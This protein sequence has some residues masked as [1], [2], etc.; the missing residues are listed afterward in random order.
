M[1]YFSAH[2]SSKKATLSGGDRR[3]VADDRPLSDRAYHEQCVSR[4][5][6]FFGPDSQEAK[7]VRQF[8]ISMPTKDVENIFKVRFKQQL[9]LVF[10]K[11]F[12]NTNALVLRIRFC[13]NFLDF[14][15]PSYRLKA[16]SKRF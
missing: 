10:H 3:Q 12:L 8:T 6:E 15:S 1:A 13:S 4:L 16:K 14:P 11:H 2:S 9:K 5:V 7:I